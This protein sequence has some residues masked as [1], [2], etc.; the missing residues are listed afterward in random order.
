MCDRTSNFCWRRIMYRRLRMS[1]VL[2]IAAFLCV[3]GISSQSHAQW[4][5]TSPATGSIR[6]PTSNV[7]GYGNATTNL[8][9]AD[10]SFSYM[11]DN[12]I[13]I[14][15]N[16][17][18]VISYQMMPNFFRWATSPT[19]LAPPQGGWKKTFYETIPG[20]PPTYTVKYLH[21]A[22]IDPGVNP[23]DTADHQVN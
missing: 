18:R 14:H 19:E 21:W 16:T 22:N 8:A 3:L 2:E 4:T 6:T 7:S 17:T 13:E 5:V 11:D 10:F 12:L 9:P 15:E 23:A 1:L 20:N